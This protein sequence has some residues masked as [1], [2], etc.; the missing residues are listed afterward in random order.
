V[1]LLTL[2][3]TGISTVDA[4]NDK[5]VL[6]CLPTAL[7]LASV[8]AV[9]KLPLPADIVFC[10]LIAPAPPM[11]VVPSAPIMRFAAVMPNTCQTELKSVCA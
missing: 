8:A 5:C 11:T 1:L 3:I 4:C 10:P 2:T 6:V 7:L 9:T